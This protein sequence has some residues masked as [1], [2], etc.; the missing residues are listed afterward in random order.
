[1]P[2]KI[3]LVEDQFDVKTVISQ[4]LELRFG[5][6]V[7]VVS[8]GDEVHKAFMSFAPDVVLMDIRLPFMNGIEAISQIR[9]MSEVPII[10]VSAHGDKRTRS[11]AASAGA[12]AFVEKPPD[13]PRLVTQMRQL[14]SQ[15]GR[16]EDEPEDPRRSTLALI[17]GH[18][19]RLAK[20]HEQ[21]ALKGSDTPPA[22]LLEIED[23]ERKIEELMHEL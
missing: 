18:K 11:L 14:M 13:M 9:A 23:I 5:F 20:L 21:A 19:R 10:V 17:S 22:I 8:R 12:D 1:M 7:E 16:V 4:W 15:R 3:L 6:E 2:I